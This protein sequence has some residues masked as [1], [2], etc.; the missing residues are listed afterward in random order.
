[1]MDLKPYEG[2]THGPWK[3]SM[4]GDA[5][6]RSWWHIQA[7]IGNYWAARTGRVD[8]GFDITHIFCLGPDA[9]LMAA[10][11]ELLA[12]VKRLQVENESLKRKIVEVDHE[13]RQIP[14]LRATNRALRAQVA[15]LEM[16]NR[17]ANAGRDNSDQLYRLAN[18]LRDEAKLL[19]SAAKVTGNKDRATHLTDVLVCVV[20]ASRQESTQ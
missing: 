10:A 8:G 11:P 13:N 4:H 7:G 17:S 18:A 19:E 2:H 15:D 14:N 1:M 12:E 3:A 16:L 20:K 9:R 5:P 6:E